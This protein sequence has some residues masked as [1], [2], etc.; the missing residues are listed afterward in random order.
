MPKPQ[1]REGVDYMTAPDWSFTLTK[2]AVYM[3][4]VQLVNV[5]QFRTMDRGELESHIF[6]LLTMNEGYRDDVAK[7]LA[8]N[9]HFQAFV[10]E[11][12]DRF[13][14]WVDSNAQ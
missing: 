1:A 3:T 8:S 12:Y 4:Q 6:A 5:P 9:T 13:K 11:I 10:H 7:R 14:E 2:K